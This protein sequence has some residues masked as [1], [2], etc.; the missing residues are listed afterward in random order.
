MFKKIAVFLISTAFLAISCLSQTPDA[1]APPAL[2]PEVLHRVQ[3]E[4]RSRYNV[5]SQV[6]IAISA[7]RISEV[8]AFDEIT[9]TFTGQG[10][11]TEHQF[12]ISRDRLT[13]ARLEKFDIST[14]FMAK[15]DVKGRP[16]RG[17]A[18][19]KV[20]IINFDDY[21]CP[22]CSRMH[23][24]LFPNILRKYG[25]QVKFIYKDYPLVEIHPWAMHAAI[26]ANC[27]AEQSTDAYWDFTDSIHEKQKV[28][29][30]DPA[31]P[32][33]AIDRLAGDLGGKR[34]VDSGKLN[35]CIAKGDESAVR[36]SMAEADKLGI[37]ST[38]TMFING[39]KIS[40]AVPEANLSAI[41]DRALTAAG[42][43]PPAEDKVPPVPPGAKR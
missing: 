6:D 38:P 22:F 2:T 24:T 28:V 12:L 25:K 3:T 30:A 21:Q 29:S 33:T 9:I 32:N 35:A 15:F 23:A 7:P 19:A 42:E 26:A 34:S 4:V 10:H 1:S 18:A 8:K 39:E 17:N 41:I 31:G 5:P 14:D 13:L 36:S 43:T 20:T 16:V 40:G 27:L 11:S 37:D